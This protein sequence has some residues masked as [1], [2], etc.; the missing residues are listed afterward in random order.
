MSVVVNKVVF[1][2]EVF[3]DGSTSVMPDGTATVAVLLKEVPFAGAGALN[4]ITIV[5]VLFTGK[6]GIVPLKLVLLIEILPPLGHVAPPVELQDTKATLVI[7]DGR[8]SFQVAFVTALG[9]LLVITTVYCI[10]CPTYT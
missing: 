8:L 6:D 5:I 3:V 7:P 4:S 2:V 1:H 9:P 10:Y